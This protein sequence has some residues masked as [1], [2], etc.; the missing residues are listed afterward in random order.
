MTSTKTDPPTGDIV[1]WALDGDWGIRGSQSQLAAL[2]TSLSA[3]Q[4][5]IGGAKRGAENPHL[6]NKY[7]DLAAYIDASA[8][9]LKDN[10][11]SVVQLPLTGRVITIL[12]HNDGGAIFGSTPIILGEGKGLNPAQVYG[13]ACTYARRYG[14]GAILDMAAEDDDAA[15]AGVG[16]GLEGKAG[17]KAQ[18]PASKPPA[19]KPTPAVSA[20]ASG[21][22]ARQPRAPVVDEGRPAAIKEIRDML[23]KAKREEASLCHWLVCESLEKA[24]NAQLNQALAALDAPFQAQ[25]AK[26]NASTSPQ[27]AAAQ[28]AAPA[29]NQGQASLL[30]P[31]PGVDED[32]Q[33]AINNVRAKLKA[34]NREET[35][36]CDWLRCESLEKATSAQLDK[37]QAALEPKQRAA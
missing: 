9:A 36:L 14:R 25:T 20:V 10:H 24:T 5:E 34:A 3:A 22:A 12:A 6:H 4:A 2:F 29:Q 16:K 33:V 32:R 37:A 17:A 35:D 15:G 23:K 28:A 8:P 1:E 7:A 19:A 18:V 31:T 21:Q 30:P 13:S 27:P 26:P 11:L